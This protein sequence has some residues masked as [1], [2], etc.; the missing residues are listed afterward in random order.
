MGTSY[1]IL[2]ESLEETIFTIQDNISHLFALLASITN[3][4]EYS[5][6]GKRFI[7]ILNKHGRR[8]RQRLTQRRQRR[9][10]VGR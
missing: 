9:L 7:L 6:T 10:L 1:L 3:I 2:Y 4:Q 5:L 8:G